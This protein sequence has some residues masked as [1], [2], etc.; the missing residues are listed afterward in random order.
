MPVEKRKFPVNHSPSLG[1]KRQLALKV[2]REI[3]R[4]K[5]K[6]F[7]ETLMHKRELICCLWKE[8]NPYSATKMSMWDLVH[9]LVRHLAL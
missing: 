3:K 9:P 1:P 7:P 5:K 8:W 2:K 4:R 6:E